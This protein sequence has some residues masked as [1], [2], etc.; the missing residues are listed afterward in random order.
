MDFG[1]LVKQKRSQMGFDL[2]ILSDECGV[3]ASTISRLENQHTQPTIGTA[4]RICSVLNISPSELT[5]ETGCSRHYPEDY[6]EGDEKCL[7]IADLEMFL[8]MTILHYEEGRKVTAS[9]LAK[10]ENLYSDYWERRG[11]NHK[12]RLQPISPDVTDLFFR[13]ISLIK[14]TIRYPESMITSDH[15]LGAYYQKGVVSLQDLRVFFSCMDIKKILNDSLFEKE[16]GYKTVKLIDNFVEGLQSLDSFVKIKFNNLLELD[17]LVHDINIL[18]M[19]WNVYK[20]E[21]GIIR[22][23]SDRAYSV[24]DKVRWESREWAIVELIV[25]M[26]RWFQVLSPTDMTWLDEL[27]ETM[28]KLEL[29]LL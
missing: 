24:F 1:T 14:C 26:S 21:S 17:Q 7:T 6:L 13:E 11:K 5:K 19:G 12:I 25:N 4:V 10:L 8:V 3:D 20:F 16:T 15:I 2:Q 22:R 23:R 9:L 27:R 29:D 28:H 18:G